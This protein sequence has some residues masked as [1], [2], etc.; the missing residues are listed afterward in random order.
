MRNQ[1]HRPSAHP[2]T[3]PSPQAVAGGAGRKAVMLLLRSDP[4]DGSIDHLSP[5]TI[6]D[7]IGAL[8]MPI[9]RLSDSY[10]MELACKE[11]ALVACSLR[12]AARVH[13]SS[14]LFARIRKPSAVIVMHTDLSFSKC[15]T[16]CSHYIRRV[17]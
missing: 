10:F 8:R 9:C 5:Q 15:T 7:D 12:R 6:G 4:I 2:A 1:V 17:M 16:V 14:D 11:R 3:G 13:T